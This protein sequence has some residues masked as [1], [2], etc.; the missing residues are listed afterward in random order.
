MMNSF[1]YDRIDKI[2]ERLKS[3][4]LEAKERELLEAEKKRLAEMCEQSNRMARL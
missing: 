2:N 4:K 3:D 1:R